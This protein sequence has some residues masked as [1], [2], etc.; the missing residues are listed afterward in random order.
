MLL[1]L[2]ETRLLLLERFEN[3][4]SQTLT[5]YDLMDFFLFYWGGGGELFHKCHGNVQYRS[6]TY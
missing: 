2:Q 1:M 6:L 3:F 5:T 4:F